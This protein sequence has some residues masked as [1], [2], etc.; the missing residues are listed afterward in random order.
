MADPFLVQL[1]PGDDNRVFRRCV[2][3]QWCKH[4]AVLAKT[5]FGGSAPTSGGYLIDVRPEDVSQTINCAT[6]AWV[7]NAS[8]QI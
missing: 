7:A 4:M 3:E 5:A 1:Q 6:V 2:I 8:A